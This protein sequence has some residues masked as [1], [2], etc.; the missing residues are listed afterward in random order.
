MVSDGLLRFLRL[1]LDVYPFPDQH[2]IDDLRWKIRM[3]FICKFSLYTQLI[4]SRH[5]I[6]LSLSVSFLTPNSNIWRG[7]GMWLTTIMLLIIVMVGKHIR[8][9]SSSSWHRG[10]VMTVSTDP[11]IQTVV[12]SARGRYTTPGC[13]WLIHMLISNMSYNNGN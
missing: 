10:V 3:K 2:A 9:S 12:T 1:K 5:P 11:V 13:G 7:M 4:L 6:D 8:S